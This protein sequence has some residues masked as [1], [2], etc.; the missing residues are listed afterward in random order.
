MLLSLGLGLGLTALLRLGG[1]LALL[2][3][4]G[5]LPDLCLRGGGSGLFGILSLIHI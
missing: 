1:L 3:G 4:F 5:L 2:L